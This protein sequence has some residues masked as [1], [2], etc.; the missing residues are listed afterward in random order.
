MTSRASRDWF[1]MP[2]S[3]ASSLAFCRLDRVRTEKRFRGAVR[4]LRANFEAKTIRRRFRSA[5][6][7]KVAWTRQ[8]EGPPRPACAS[9]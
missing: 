7:R 8:R 2:C 4:V 9:K 1:R 6:C 5:K 3:F